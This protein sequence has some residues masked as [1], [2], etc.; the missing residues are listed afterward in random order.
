[1]KDYAVTMVIILS[2]M[3]SGLESS[4]F[5]LHVFIK[6]KFVRQTEQFSLST[7]LGN[8]ASSQGYYAKMTTELCQKI[9]FGDYG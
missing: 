1:M 2:S 5:D 7:K 6:P 4:I 8:Y 9:H 3:N